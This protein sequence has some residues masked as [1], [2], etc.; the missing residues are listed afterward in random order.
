MNVRAAIAQG[1]V[2]GIGGF[3][4]FVELV[5]GSDGMGGGLGRGGEA[6]RFGDFGVGLEFIG[7]FHDRTSQGWAADHLPV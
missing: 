1:P 4:Y 2:G 7:K 6:L 3:G 5:F